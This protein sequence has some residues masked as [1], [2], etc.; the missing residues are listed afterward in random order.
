MEKEAYRVL[1]YYLYTDIENPEER[2]QQHL[3]YCKSIGLKGRILIAGEGIN[4]TV[5]GTY[6]QTEQYMRDMKADPVFQH[7]EFKIDEA[8]SHVFKKMFVRARS[9][10]VTLRL[11]EEDVDPREVT[12]NYLSPKEW[13]KKMQDP[14]TLILDARN[15]YEYDLGHFD[16]AI[17][18]DIDYFRELPEWVD[19]NRE[20]LEGKEIMTYCTGGIRCEK[21]SGWLVEKGFDQVNHLEGGIVTYGKDPEVRGKRWNGQ[22]YVFDERISVPINQEEHVIVARDY[23]SG[24][25]C[26]RYV[27]CANPAC[28]KQIIIS[29]ETEAFY[30][31]ACCRECR[32]SP[33]NRYVIK[34]GLSEEEVEMQLKKIE[35]YTHA[36]QK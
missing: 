2:A 26:E 34:K 21:F 28:N 32:V 1:L 9:E 12:G 15:K 33:R 13:Y 23:F 4:G 30:L 29:E 17:R 31:G 8:E 11:N 35:E 7:I 27:N 36:L 14:N 5:S 3:E 25:P 16:G 19:N 18:P 6:E 10:L 20:L 22:C 24:E